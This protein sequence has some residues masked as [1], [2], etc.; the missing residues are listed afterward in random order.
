M[1]SGR[2]RLID[3]DEPGGVTH[4][5]VTKRNLRAVR[6]SELGGLL[7]LQLRRG[8][9]NT[10]HQNGQRDYDC[11]HS[12]SPPAQVCGLKYFSC[13]QFDRSLS[14]RS[15]RLQVIPPQGSPL[16]RSR[17]PSGTGLSL[18][19][20][21]CIPSCHPLAM[22]CTTQSAWPYACCAE[23]SVVRLPRPEAGKRLFR[24]CFPSDGRT[25]AKPPR[26]LCTC[27]VAI[28]C[29]VRVLRGRK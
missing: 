15:G 29:P 22:R 23:R 16:L 1:R 4:V 13:H 26:T 12:L 8:H 5:K 21:V 25:I 17:P 9:A 19:C 24:G 14:S 2:R 7:D 10:E 6:T 11:P 3:R 20:G 27:E 28:T 18:F